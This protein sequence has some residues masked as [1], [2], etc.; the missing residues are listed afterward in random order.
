MPPF[1]KQKRTSKEC[2]RTTGGKYDAKK[3]YKNNN[4]IKKNSKK[5][6]FDLRNDE[7]VSSEF[8]N[9]DEDWGDDDDSGWDDPEDIEAETQIHQRLRGID[10]V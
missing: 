3:V 8:F 4:L 10:L 9:K 5:N 1:S 7:T 6:N 2:S